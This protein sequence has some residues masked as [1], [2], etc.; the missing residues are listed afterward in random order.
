MPVPHRPRLW[1]ISYKSLSQ[2]I[3]SLLPEYAPFAD[4]HIVDTLLEDALHTAQDLMRSH[5]A[6]VFLSAGANGKLLRHHVAVPVAI[7]KVTGFDILH[8]L[9]RAQA[10][11]DRIALLT[12]EEIGREA[13]RVRP[14]LSFDLAIRTYR[15][16]AEARDAFNDLVA[17]GYQAF[18]G[19]SLVV[20]LAEQ[21][22]R[23][24]VL[25]YSANAVREALNDA[26]ELA[27][28]ARIE[29]AKGERLNAI[30]RHLHEGV[31]AVDMDHRIEAMNP[32][33]EQLLGVSGAWAIGRPL[34][35]VAPGLSLAATLREGL[36][37]VNSVERHNGRQ[38]IV[39][40]VPIVE[41]SSRTGAMLTCQDAAAVERADRRLRQQTRPRSQRARYGLEQ[42]L[43]RST[44]ITRARNIAMRYADAGATVLIT[45][46]SG[47]GKE[48]FAQGMHNASHRRGGPFV[49]L[50]CAAVPE[51]LL[52]SELFGYEEGAFT[53]SRRG[54]KG[55]LFEAAHQ[56]TLFLDE[57]G[58]MPASLQTRLLRVLQEREVLRLGGTE[59]IPVDVR[60]IAATHRDLRS[61][62]REGLFRED[63]Y[64]RLN[65]LHLHLPPLRARR[66]D[67]PVIAT[68]LLRQA[69]GR[70]GSSADP[71][72]LLQH[73]LPRLIGHDWQGNVRE[74]ENVIER[75]AVFHG[76]IDGESDLALIAPELFS[77]PLT[78]QPASALEDNTSALYQLQRALTECQGD[79]KAAAAQ[80]GISRTTLWRRLRAAG[81]APR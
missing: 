44:A 68:D 17:E 39:S 61:R 37:D 31:L 38:V 58:D 77:A 76:E 4:I 27:R 73:A 50:N 1:V 19:S 25:V 36:S 20:E 74:L 34:A 29:E 6:D 18:L 45:G 3:D 23:H 43:G 63:L 21:A 24:G 66:D 56:G 47:T 49:A 7:I 65:I 33:L 72:Q 2:L 80:L 10:L 79:R 28:V 13:E 9:R 40:R 57:I 41:G 81:L 8:A 48:L 51:T 67:I 55:G 78:T 60:V 53:G 12:Y 14:L 59:P 62:I 75:L 54:G 42:V 69:L 52:E 64:F 46:E 71:A 30:L 22:N 15:T 35:E 70:L 26:L 11:T 5:K 32:A 16:I